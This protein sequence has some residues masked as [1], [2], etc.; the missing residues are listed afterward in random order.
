M[1]S[2]LQARPAAMDRGPSRPA[3]VGFAGAL[4]VINLVLLHRA[5]GWQIFHNSDS[6]AMLGAARAAGWRDALGWITGPWIGASLC[7]YYR[8]TSSWLMWGE[9]GLFGWHSA[10]YQSV[11]MLLHLAAALLF[12]RLAAGLLGGELLGAVAALIFSL[13]PSNVRTLAV[14]T[15]QPDL[16]AAAFMFLALLVLAHSLPRVRAASRAPLLAGSLVAA[17]LSLGGKESALS[18]PA[19]ASLVIVFDRRSPRRRQAWLLIAYWATFAAFMAGRSL[20]MS[21]LGYI[22]QGWREPM[23]AITTYGRSAGLYFAY[24]FAA[25]AVSSEWWPLMMFAI[26]AAYF[27]AAQRWR[28]LRKERVLLYAAAPAIIIAA[29]LLAAACYGHWV[30]ALTLAPWRQLGMMAAY[31]LGAGLVIWRN[32]RMA[33][34]VVLW[35]LFAF[36]PA[37]YRVYDWSGKYFYLPHTFWALYGALLLEAVVTA[38]AARRRAPTRSP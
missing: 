15:A 16:V 1:T 34:F 11:S 3:L 10:G 18:L 24:P 35:G 31:A 26:T 22:P 4:I 8:P 36:A 21:G 9:W 33:L 37:A 6:E 29:F 13:R 20:A 12:W 27:A 28:S 38:T 7:N 17:L 14:L 25:A 30:A 32:W 23:H 5:I 19:L 2:G